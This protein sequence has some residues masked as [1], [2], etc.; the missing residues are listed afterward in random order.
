MNAARQ[1]LDTSVAKFSEACELVLI[2]K[3]QL[4]MVDNRRVATAPLVLSSGGADEIALFTKR[5]EAEMDNG[6]V[7][8]AAFKSGNARCRVKFEIDTVGLVRRRKFTTPYAR[9][10]SS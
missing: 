5:T 4:G 8:R 10:A 7:F 2:S 3:N 6:G 9:F 1:V